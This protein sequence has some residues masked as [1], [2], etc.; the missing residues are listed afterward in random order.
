[1]MDCTITFV[2]QV[3]F[4]SRCRLGLEGSGQVC[5]FLFQQGGWL[6]IL[7]EQ[8]F[9]LEAAYWLKLSD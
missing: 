3:Q 9:L 1:M 4:T 8:R 2:R 6:L 7:G 5:R